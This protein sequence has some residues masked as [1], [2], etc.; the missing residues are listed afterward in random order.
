MA[1]SD[2]LISYWSLE[3][4][5]GA[6]AIDAKGTNTLA[7]NGTGGVGSGV[8][9][10]ANARVFSH[11]NNTYLSVASNSSLQT[12]DIDFT[13]T[14]WV[15]FTTDISGQSNFGII[16]KAS[17][18]GTSTTEYWIDWQETNNCIR[19]VVTDSSNYGEAHWSSSPSTGTWY[20]VVAWHDSVNNV[21]GIN[22]NNGTSVTTAWSAGTHS[23]SNAFK[24]GELGTLNRQMDGTIDEV[25][26]WKRVLTGA[27]ITDL[28]NSG[29]GRAYSYINPTISGRKRQSQIIM[30][31][32]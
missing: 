28:Y 22:V 9:K 11:V 8:G 23:L 5:S 24:I 13:F 10:V 30:M 29:N 4:A 3:E 18:A 19:I 12:G 16:S 27:E 17:D 2:N 21:V 15:N 20:F 14:C 7:S 6:S 31:D 32:E 26:F 1:L 25:G